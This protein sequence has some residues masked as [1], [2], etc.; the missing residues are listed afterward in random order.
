MVHVLY[1]S[2]V[3]NWVREKGLRF[4]GIPKFIGS[5]SLVHDSMQYHFMVMERYGNDL[6]KT[7]EA[8]G[9]RFSVKTVCYLA[10]RLVSEGYVC[11]ASAK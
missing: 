5:G 9:R 3:E 4:L 7:F 10:L 2:P 1:L 6:Q 8:L 11:T